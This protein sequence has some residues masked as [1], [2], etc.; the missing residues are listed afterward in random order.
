MVN[1]AIISSDIDQLVEGN[2]DILGDL[3]F[4]MA[5]LSELTEAEVNTINR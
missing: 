1:E 4:E 2:C 5:E 3:S